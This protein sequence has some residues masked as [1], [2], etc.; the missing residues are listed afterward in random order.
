MQKNSNLLNN[1]DFPKPFKNYKNMKY[2][3]GI[4]CGNSLYLSGSMPEVT[5]V[6]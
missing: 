6:R 1:R 4:R 5:P 3:Y 2:R